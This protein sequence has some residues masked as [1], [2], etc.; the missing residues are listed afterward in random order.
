MKIAITFHG[1]MR[2]SDW[3]STEIH[4]VKKSSK[5]QLTRISIQI[6]HLSIDNQNDFIH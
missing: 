5:R 1:Y 4:C 2:N 3:V 6:R